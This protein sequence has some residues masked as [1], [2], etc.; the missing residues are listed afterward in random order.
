MKRKVIYIAS[1]YSADTD[2]KFEAQ[3][4]T[5]KDI[6]REVVLGGFNAIVPHLSLPLCLDDKKEEERALGLELAIE[7]MLLCDM[8]FVH[9]GMGVSKGMEAEIGVARE[10]E[11][12]TYYFRNMK[13]LKD[14]IKWIKLDASQE[15]KK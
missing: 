12:K 13:D 14:I 15:T 4:Q 11:I 5:T 2:E 7:Q 3:L 6:T 8:L 10:K 1:R 9:I